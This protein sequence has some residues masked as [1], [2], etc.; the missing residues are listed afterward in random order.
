MNPVGT[1]D[2]SFFEQLK[3]VEKDHFWFEV[4]RRWIYD[5]VLPFIPSR[6]RVLEVGCGTGNISSYFARMGHDVFGCEFYAQAISMSWPGFQGVRGDSN[7]LPFR[8]GSFDLVGVFDVIEHFEDDRLPL[9]EAARIVRSGGIV[10]VTVPSRSELWSSVDEIA[11]HKRRYDKEMI[12]H[13][14]SGAGLK[15]ALTEY[16]FMSLYLPMKLLRGKQKEPAL[17]LRTGTV[18]NFLLKGLFHLER[19]VSRQVPLPIGTSIIAVA[20]TLQ[21]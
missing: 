12:H 20:R 9:L 17:E 5:K 21:S 1:Y 6:A 7:R 11:L 16:L 3:A 19:V 15:P 8:D 13:L 18:A 14:L 10:A 4:R 2:A